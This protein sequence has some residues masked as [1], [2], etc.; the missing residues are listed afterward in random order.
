MD[1]Q[2][3]ERS[4]QLAE[5]ADAARAAAKGQGGVVLLHGEAGIGKSS[6]VDA[7]RGLLPA[8]GR[9][10]VGYCDDLSTARTLGPF[11]DLV[12]VVSAGLCRA[13]QDDPDRDRI[14]SALLTEL[15]WPRHPTVLALEDL[16]WADDATLDAV[17]FL[18][19]RIR[20]LPAV[21]L[22][23]YRDDELAIDHPLRA[24][25]G[26]LA[27]VEG[28]RRLPLPR[29]SVEAV[30]A[31]AGDGASAERIFAVTSGNPFFVAESLSS[32]VDDVP[33]SVADAVLARVLRLDAGSR[34][35][36]EQLAV[37][38]WSLEP[39]LVD[40][41]VDDARTLD[42]AQ[43]IGLLEAHHGRVAFRHDLTRRA[44]ADAV[45]TP[46]AEQLHQNVVSALLSRSD[47]DSARVMHHATLARDHEVIARYG[48]A[49]AAEAARTGAHREASAH[50]RT[51][52][53]EENL[54]GA[55]DRCT[56]LQGYAVECYTIGHTQAAVS[57]QLE[58]VDLL[59]T[60]G[61]PTALGEALR[62]LSRMQWWHGDRLAAESSAQEA[63]ATLEPLGTT[64]ALAMAYSNIAQLDMLAYRRTAVPLARQAL[65]AARTS[66]DPDP[67]TLSH[68]LNNLGAARYHIGDRGGLDELLES[69]RIA[70]ANNEIEHAC[71]AYVNLTWCHV[72]DFLLDQAQDYARSG[73]DLARETEQL[74]F[75]DYFSLSE[76]RIR[77]HRADWSGAVAALD[78][79]SS[80]P[81]LRSPALALRGRIATRHGET[82]SGDLLRGALARA[83]ST[84]E[85][86]WQAVAAAATAERAWLR[87]DLATVARIAYPPFAEATRTGAGLVW[88]ELGYWVSKVDPDLRLDPSDH[89]YALLVA[90]RCHEAA[91]RWRDGGCPYEQALALSESSDTDDQLAALHTL[92]GIG[93]AP[94]ARI[95]RAR[96]RRGGV[97]HIP[98]G[99]APVTQANPAGLTNRQLDIL[100]HLMTGASNADIADRLVVSIRTVDNHV[101]ATLQKL[102][103]HSRSSAVTRAREL[104]VR[105][106]RDE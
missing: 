17:Q 45:P 60:R 9:L 66:A 12:G 94:L 88:P 6:L 20:T 103:V 76:A 105:P 63:V 43:H 83:D 32:G 73:L 13:L 25:L 72:D 99:P 53:R 52:V 40:L 44:I 79:L 19:R 91:T 37:V 38:P 7:L 56:Y 5:L 26:V 15:N 8:E 64:S 86:L 30:R 48:P 36:L 75:G 71:R 54:P 61:D 41:L 16:H 23:T 98:R 10:L 51:L 93:A 27:R 87:G 97:T 11:R 2:I 95:V 80:R 69:L 58:A 42:R 81:L 100:R 96:L 101:A 78:Q 49:A 70:L 39:W 33:R 55:G 62:W 102:D 34:A 47:V 57:A 77:M 24:L 92:D 1:R 31:L 68:A 22:L 74:S 29:L 85:P 3:L 104:G 90:G 50:Y 18:A 82:G 4:E 21:L 46:R 28:T 84:H 65:A 59:R 14:F 67:G 89:P 106:A 35:A